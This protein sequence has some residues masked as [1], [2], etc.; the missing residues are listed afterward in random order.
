MDLVKF[1]IL[2]ASTPTIVVLLIGLLLGLQVD[3]MRG[4]YIQDQLKE[5]DLEMQN[6][7]VTQNYLDDSTNNY[8]GFVETRTPEL[9]RQNTEIGSNLQSFSGKSLSNSQEFKFL[10]H[11]YYVNQLRLKLIS[12]FE[13]Q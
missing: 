8:C 12:G 6:F 5:S 4:N 13:P 10:A 2:E 3:D 1:S 7:L 11:K 9:P